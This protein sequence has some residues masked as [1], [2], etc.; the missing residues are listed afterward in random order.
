MRLKAS[1]YVQL[2]V[3]R[4]LIIAEK[5][6][7]SL[8]EEIRALM[9]ACYNRHAHGPKF[10]LGSSLSETK[11]MLVMGDQWV[12]KAFLSLINNSTK[13]E[14]FPPSSVIIIEVFGR[15]MVRVFYNDE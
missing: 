14:Y 4:L 6:N 13:W 9:Q 7:L 15:G 3:A 5:E 12:A 1:E 2:L 11:F 10:G 8:S